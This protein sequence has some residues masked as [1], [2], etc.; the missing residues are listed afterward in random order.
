MKKTYTINLGGMAF[1]IDEDAYIKLNDYLDSIKNH[2]ENENE[3]KEILEDI[4]LR[5]AEILKD[6]L[7]SKKE[8]ISTVDIDNI[9]KIM[10]NPSEFG[11]EDEPQAKQEDDKERSYKRIYRDPDNRVIG[12]VCG[13]LGAYFQF[14][15]IILRVLFVIALLGLGTGFFIYIILW[16]VIPEA[17][18]FAQKM[19]MRGEEVNISNIGKKVKEEFDN[20]KNNIKH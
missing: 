14:D 7:S 9:I 10:G 17:K 12:G 4:E 16:I 6:T 18:T 13:G 8:V 3:R 2:F 20:V 5:I 15:P 1:V 11:P 19:Q